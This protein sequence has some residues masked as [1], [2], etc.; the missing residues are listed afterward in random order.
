ALPSIMRSFSI[1]LAATQLVVLA[2]LSIITISLV[3]WG[4]I[5]DIWGRGE[6]YLKGMLIFAGASIG[7]YLSASLVPLIL[8][9]CIQGL[10]AAMMMSSGPAIIKMVFP[11][12]QLGRGLGLI[13]LATSCG[14]MCGPVVSGFLI[15]YFSWRLIF[16]VTLPVSVFM[17]IIGHICLLSHL[18]NTVE[19][20]KK[21]FDWLGFS[22]WGFL[23]VFFVIL[24][25]LTET[26]T[27]GRYAIASILF[28][29]LLTLFFRLERYVQE[30]LIPFFLFRE[31]YFSTAV[32]TAG[33]SFGILF[34]ILLL[35]PFYLDYILGLSADR[36][37]LVMLAVPV[38]LVVVSPLSGWLYDKK[39]ARMLTTLGLAV[40]CLAILTMLSL[41]GDSKE[42]GVAARLAL[43][44]A[45][46]A[47]FL[48][49]NSASVLARVSEGYTGVAAGILAT[50]RNLGMLLG[51]GLSGLIF[52][53]I[54][55]LFSGG[56]S[57]HTFQPGQTEVFML[58]L[59]WTF[60]LAAIMAA[61]G[62]VLSSLRER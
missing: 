4:H 6:I 20:Q 22:L 19:R 5:A 35:I 53:I 27:A 12:D 59:R 45:G 1:S 44:G 37:G 31:R 55:S 40:S 34:I 39:G 16:L 24:V 23:V 42:V 13:G 3:F 57:L 58:S 2:Y 47:I 56:G 15:H 61:L 30:P 54:F 10:G 46:Q 51:V 9:R 52:S 50:A 18:Q 48:S 29:A 17:C 38:T 36:I 33:L 14:L 60:G 49:P 43:L 41:D 62:C 11:A 28:I 25:S 26:M 32:V 21:R 8:F 7:C